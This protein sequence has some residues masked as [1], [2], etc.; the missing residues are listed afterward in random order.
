[1]M[2]KEKKGGRR[3]KKAKISFESVEKFKYL[4]KT[5]TNETCTHK[6]VKSRLKFSV[7]CLAV[8]YR[9]SED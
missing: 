7:L 3:S 2:T 4:G 1:M 9:E 5:V 6:D 8:C